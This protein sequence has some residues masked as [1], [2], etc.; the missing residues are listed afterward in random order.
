MQTSIGVDIG[1]TFTDVVAV[2]D[3][4]RMR[5]AKVPS[6]RSDPSA[7]V[8]TVLA[9]LLPEWRIE[10]E[11]RAALRPRHDGR[12]QRRA[13]AQ[14]RAAR[15]AHDRG[16]H[17]RARDRPAEPAP[18]LRPDARS[19][20]R[21]A[22]SPRARAAAAWSRR[23][24]PHGEVR[25]AARRGV[26]RSERRRAARRGRRGDR[27]LL[28]L[29]LR[30]SGARAGRP[31]HGSASGIPALVVSLSSRGRSGVPRIRAHRRHRVRRL[32]E[33]R[34]RPLPRRHGS[35]TSRATGVPAPLQIMQSRGGVCI[36]AH[37]ARSGRSGS[38]S[39]GPAAGVVGALR[40]RPR[41]SATRT[42]SRSTSAAPAPTS[43]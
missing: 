1:G 7:A 37:R 43:R 33:A 41:R 40:D 14:G 26:A 16:L 21:R 2:D 42:S 27:D 39:P 30:Q 38:S 11:Q 17:G 18:D 23:S 35:A 19:P 15:A 3:D 4:G 9:R 8:R 13:R 36:G 28:P 31:P 29:L 25:D 6:T 10:A 5:I 24:S 34:P 32:R 20:R 22:S 12:D